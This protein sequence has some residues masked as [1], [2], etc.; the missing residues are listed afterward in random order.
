MPVSCA[1]RP[2]ELRNRRHDSSTTT[3]DLSALLGLTSA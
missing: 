1:Q 3:A 2:F